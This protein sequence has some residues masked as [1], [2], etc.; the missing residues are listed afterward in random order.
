[1]ILLKKKRK[2]LTLII[3]GTEA[4]L[5]TKN[6]SPTLSLCAGQIW[7]AVDNKIDDIIERK[8]DCLCILN[9]NITSLIYIYSFFVV[10]NSLLFINRYMYNTNTIQRLQIPHTDT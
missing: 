3:H 9:I 2:L 7:F 10:F 1:M 4:S 5:Y 6:I 8:W